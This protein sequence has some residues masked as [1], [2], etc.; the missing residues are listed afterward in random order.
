MEKCEMLEVGGAYRVFLSQEI[1][2]QF[3]ETS[4]YVLPAEEKGVV[5]CEIPQRECPYGNE[6]RR[7]LYTDLDSLEVEVSICTSN[8]LVEKAG[9][10]EVK[11]NSKGEID[12]DRHRAF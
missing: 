3:L 10:L 7:V 6:G 12:K 4:A 2:R 9:L 5:L 11:K 8:G 1:R